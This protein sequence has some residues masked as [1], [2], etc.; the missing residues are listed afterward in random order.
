MGNSMNCWHASEKPRTSLL[1]AVTRQTAAELIVARA[2]TQKPN[3]G[4][5]TWKGNIVRK[6]DVIIVKNYLQNDEKPI[7]RDGNHQNY[8]KEIWEDDFSHLF[9]AF[10]GKIVTFANY[11]PVANHR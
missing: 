5:T 4:L 8:Q 2:D 1:Y 11:I 10:Y 9:F 6:G 3:M 7:N